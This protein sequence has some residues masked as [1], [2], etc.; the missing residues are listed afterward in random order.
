MCYEVQENR[1]GV[2]KISWV[3]ILPDSQA[4]LAISIDIKSPSKLFIFSGGL[5]EPNK[6]IHG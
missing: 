5:S 3:E 1:Q 4:N 6:F 2:W